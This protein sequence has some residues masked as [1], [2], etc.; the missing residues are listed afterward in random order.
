MTKTIIIFLLICTLT[1]GS[2]YSSDM[3]GFNFLRTHVGARMS[4]IAG[5]GV[6]IPGD[7]SLIYFN[8]AGLAAINNQTIAIMYLKHVLDF[9]SGFIGYSHPLKRIGTV[10]AAINYM[11]YGSFDE[12]D[13]DVF[14][15]VT[16]LIDKIKD[17]D[18]VSFDI[19]EDQR[20]PKAINVRL[21][22][23]DGS[24]G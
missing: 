17:D 19:V 22:A 4:A 3:A 20:G 9:H 7:I 23:S 15:H 1:F 11:D 18:M 14:V 24:A 2:L 6:A 8:P 13:K 10:A 5:A 12:T 21:R 16:G